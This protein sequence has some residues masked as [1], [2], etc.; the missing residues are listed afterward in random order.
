MQNN[1]AVLTQSHKAIAAKKK[2]K[3][4]QIKEIIFDDDARRQVECRSPITHHLILRHR[5]FLT[6]FHKRK[7]A[8]ADAARK[9]AIEREKQERLESRR[10]VCWSFSIQLSL[11]L[12]I[13]P[14]SNGAC[15]ENELRKM[16]KRWRWLM[17]HY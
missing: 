16:L 10:E 6:G 8:K 2:A 15:S 5:E 3:R 11:L 12:L 17:V 9:K 4:D 1:L 13:Y 7:L 14:S